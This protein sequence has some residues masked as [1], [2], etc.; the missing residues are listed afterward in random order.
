MMCL[1][2][3]HTQFHCQRHN[4]N[5]DSKS[6]SSVNS[7]IQNGGGKQNSFILFSKLS[8]GLDGLEKSDKRVGILLSE[9]NLINNIKTPDEQEKEGG[10]DYNYAHTTN[11]T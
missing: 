11:L 4:I 2:T 9:K 7:I 5:N 1:L 10:V 3:A 8:Y 6:T